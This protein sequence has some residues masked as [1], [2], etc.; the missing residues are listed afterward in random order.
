M[1][2]RKGHRENAMQGKDVIGVSSKEDD[3]KRS[4]RETGKEGRR[5]FP[6]LERILLRPRQALKDH[7][8]RRRVEDGRRGEGAA[9]HQD[10]EP[11][12]AALRRFSGVIQIIAVSPV[13]LAHISDG[14]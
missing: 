2:K 5:G 9:P 11:G 8:G 3:W 12:S 4:G 6:V 7:W 14:S 10:V 1:L 13:F